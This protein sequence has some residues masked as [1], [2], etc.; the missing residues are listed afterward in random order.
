MSHKLHLLL[1]PLPTDT[2]TLPTLDNFNL[3]VSRAKKMLWHY[4]NYD[5]CL[6]HLFGFQQEFLPIAPVTALADGQ[7]IDKKVTYL[8]AD[9]IYLRADRDK[10]YLFDAD[11]ALQ[12]LTLNEAQQLVNS[13]NKHFAQEGLIF[14]APTLHRWYLQ[15][16]SQ[17]KVIFSSLSEAKG[18]D[19]HDYM[20]EGEDRLKW[21]SYLNEI[22]MLLYQNPVNEQRE[23]DRKL[24]VNSV[25]FWGMGQLPELTKQDWSQVWSN[26]ILTKGLAELSGVEYSALPSQVEMILQ[27]T[28]KQL[29]VFDKIDWQN[30]DTVWLPL[31]FNAL[32]KQQVTEIILYTNKGIFNLNVRLLKKWWKWK[33]NWLDIV[34]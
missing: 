32:R 7:A 25:W 3:L 28:G 12:D 8:R 26:D 14:S 20:P 17:P 22:Q 23:I 4:P 11:S 10:V 24:A 6:F 16:K 19:I 15:L 5:A 18:A 30:F 13:L 29:I 2:G 27:Q 31:L 1:P 33:K 9:P 34:C 21:R